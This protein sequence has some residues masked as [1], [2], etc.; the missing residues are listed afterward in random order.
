[1]ADY[2]SS[3]TGQQIDTAVGYANNAV[4]KDSQTLSESEIT[5]VLENLGFE[6]IE[7]I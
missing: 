6:Y 3:Y 7:D 5:Q 2:N 1:M 4:R